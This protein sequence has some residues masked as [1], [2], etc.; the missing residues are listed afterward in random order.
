VALA[1]YELE[2]SIQ[3]LSIHEKER[4]L[5]PVGHFNFPLE[6][7]LPIGAMDID[8]PAARS[9]FDVE[10]AVGVR[11]GVRRG[12]RRSAF[13]KSKRAW[14]IGR[15]SPRTTFPCTS[16]VELEAMRSSFTPLG[17]TG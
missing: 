9:Q 15:L 8:E 2:M 14:L 7:R 12:S 11:L 4:A 10:L 16:L 1:S 13:T 3:S 6:D 5:V 17:G